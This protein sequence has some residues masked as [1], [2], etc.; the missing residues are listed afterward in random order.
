LPTRYRNG[1]SCVSTYLRSGGLCQ[2]YVSAITSYLDDK[3]GYC[4]LFIILWH[5]W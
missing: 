1:Q 4:Q 5:V 2:L 3:V